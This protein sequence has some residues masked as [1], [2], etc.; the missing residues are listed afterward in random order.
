MQSLSLRLFLVSGL[1]N[2]K[3]AHRAN[4]LKSGRTQYT[5]AN[6]PSGKTIRY[7]TGECKS[8]GKREVYPSASLSVLDRETLVLWNNLR[9]GLQH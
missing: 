7:L 5:L 8:R 3:N 4:R 9:M 2:E 6:R 1:K